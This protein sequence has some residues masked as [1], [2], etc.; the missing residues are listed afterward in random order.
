MF[1]HW[2]IL[3][4]TAETLVRKTAGLDKN[5]IDLVFTNEGHRHNKSGLKK[6][7]GRR[8]FHEALIAAAPE[9]VGGDKY[10][11]DMHTVFSNIATEWRKNG[12]RPTT[13]IVFT[14]GVWKQTHMNLVNDTILKIAGGF[15]STG[16]RSFSIQFIRFGEAGK[17]RLEELDN[18]LCRSRD[19]K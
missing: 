19:L 7:Q 9:R 18:D 17:E 2:P 3:F 5:G 6:D 8:I 12:H 15:G 1:D 16:K 13:L 4:F 10:Q 14:D 11:A